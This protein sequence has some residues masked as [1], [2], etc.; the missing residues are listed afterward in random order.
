VFSI[1][2]NNTACTR[3]Y[4]PTPEVTLLSSHLSYSHCQ[5]Y[6]IDCSSPSHCHSSV[7]PT[8]PSS[9][10]TTILLSNSPYFI[11]CPSTM[12]FQYSNWNILE[13]IFNH[14]LPELKPFYGPLL[15]RIRLLNLISIQYGPCQPHTT[16][17]L[18]H[19]L[20]HTLD[21]FLLLLDQNCSY[22]VILSAWNSL[23]YILHLLLSL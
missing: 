8:F 13:N 19:C 1:S 16:L 14:L 15:W 12:Q 20:P 18:T 9:L 17:S 3:L 5:R 4:N 22:H 21:F 11:L 7:Q 23:L 6:T 2:L 10:I